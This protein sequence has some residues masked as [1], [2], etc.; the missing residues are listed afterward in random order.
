MTTPSS[1][2]SSRRAIPEV[3]F[4]L[5]DI[6]QDN[7][8]GPFMRYDPLYDEIRLARQEDDPRLSMGIWKTDIKRAD[9]GIVEN[10]CIEALTTKSKDIQLGAWL[11]EAWTSL[12]GLKGYQLGIQLL[13]GLLDVFW[14]DIHPQPLDD[15]MESREMIFEWMDSALSERLM[16]VPL[17]DSKY[18]QSM[19]GLGF[20]K[21]AQHSDASQKRVQNT[22]PSTRPVDPSKVLGTVEDFQK[23]LDQTP[24][25]FLS[26]Q[27]K[28][29]LE[30]IETTQSFKNRVASLLGSASP[31]FSKILGTLKEM[32]RIVSTNLQLREP[33][34]EPVPEA[35]IPE[36]EPE[37]TLVSIPTS[38]PELQPVPTVAAPIE[39]VPP[40]SPTPQ[41]SAPLEQPPAGKLDLKTRDDAYHQLGIIASFLEEHDPQSLAPQ[42]I[43]QLLGW[44]NKNVVDIFGEIAKTP[45]EL[46]ILMKLLGS[47][48]IKK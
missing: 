21:T 42:L 7:P 10:L 32:E 17:T 39:A 30:A 37:P 26:S 8:V 24:L 28:Y 29:V 38:A 14:K 1:P 19:F 48:L 34:P 12:D 45:Q 31:S 5:K 2:L 33:I 40:S 44:Q 11:T 43:R 36:P 13:S 27:Q 9:W 25:P 22:P 3:A 15:D 18:D 41:S 46:D 47:S 20:F 23:S 6:S 4:F 35:S 16:L